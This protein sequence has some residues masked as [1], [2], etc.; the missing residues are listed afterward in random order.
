MTVME[1]RL[2]APD[3]RKFQASSRPRTLKLRAKG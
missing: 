1:L 3:G 2:E